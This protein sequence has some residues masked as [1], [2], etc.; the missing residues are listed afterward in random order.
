MME[1]DKTKKVAI[2]TGG[3]RG[4]GRSI[5]IAL[6]E[7]GIQ[8]I[9]C[10]VHG[11]EQALETVK[12]CEDKGVKA[13]AIKADVADA[14]DVEALFAMV[15]EN[16]GTID[17]LVNNAGI[18]KDDL[19]LRM[20]E[21]KFS[22]VIDT[23][24]KGAFYCTKEAAKMMLKKHAGKII[25]IS[26][27]VGV[28]GNAGQSNYAA[29]KAGLIGFAKATA[30]ELGS[31]NITANVV[32]PGFMETDMTAALSEEASKSYVQQIPLRRLGKAEDVANA[33]TFLVSDQANYMTGQ[34]LMVDGGMGM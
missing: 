28:H 10:Y 23:N 22:Q 24:L 21:E 25:F 8:I 13:M 30:K 27:V 20:T 33:V 18:T 12:A 3:S 31:K 2:V 6:A 9:T 1:V 15:K 7:Q 5:C 4:I 32:A 26:S 14:K 17:I 34:V 16:F 19:L 29:S 11:S